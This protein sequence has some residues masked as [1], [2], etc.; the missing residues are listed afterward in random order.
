M[1]NT[2]CGI[3]GNRNCAAGNQADW[4]VYW[5]REE[6]SLQQQATKTQTPEEIERFLE[7]AK[8]IRDAQDAL[9]I[10]MCEACPYRG[11]LTLLFGRMERR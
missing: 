8:A 5:Q 4:K 3:T 10:E 2:I 6:E 11:N 1:T 7:E 9:P